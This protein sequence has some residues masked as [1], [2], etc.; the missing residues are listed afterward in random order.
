M[1]FRDSC[2]REARS[3]D[4]SGWVTNEADGSVSAWFEGSPG[5]VERLVEW[6]RHGPPG[7]RVEAI[8][9]SAVEPQGLAGFEVR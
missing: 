9:V 5:D 7:A 3:H 6:S 2:R 8:E 1:F 4:V